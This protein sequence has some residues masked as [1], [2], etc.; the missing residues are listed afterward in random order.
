ML[1]V[2]KNVYGGKD[3]GRTWNEFLVDK[4]L[5]IGF[6][7]SKFDPCLFYKG[8]AMY[9]LYTDDSILAGP[10]KQEL[11]QIVSDMR[12]TKLDLTHEGDLEDFLGVHIQRDQEAG[13]F[14][15][16]Q[17]RLITSILEE[18]GLDKDNA[19]IK[20]TPGASSKLLSRHPNSEPFDGHF[21]Y[22]RIIGKLNFLEKSTRADLA[23][24]V[25]QC[26]RFSVDPKTEHGKAV[27]WIGRYLKGTADKGCIMKPDASLGLE[28]H[29]D[30]DFAGAWDSE[31]A[32]IDIDTA[33]SRHGYI[34]RYA[35]VPIMWQSQLQTEIAL[36]T[37]ESELIGMSMALRN[38]IPVMGILNEMREKGYKVHP[39]STA[40][41][42][43][44]VFE[45]NNSAL[46]IAQVPKLR[47]RT[48]HINCKFFHF[49]HFVLQGKITL[50]KIHTDEQPADFLTKM[51]DEAKFVK[52]RKFTL[53][54]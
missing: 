18:L 52:H 24:P 11:E 12:D 45:D 28:V 46:A 30:A 34:I 36:S 54:W 39:T 3:A 25:H 23:Y 2:I 7:Q 27:K 50:H 5:R 21:H 41:F 42:K 37:T 38:A 53:G 10:D 31:L 26:A 51:L 43:C 15:M 33:R 22:R 40:E 48:K 29:V 19:T 13:T 35:G 17:P 4:L 47:P 14:N 6:E 8:K 16:T 49:A 1:K 9:V 44:K 32:G 20:P